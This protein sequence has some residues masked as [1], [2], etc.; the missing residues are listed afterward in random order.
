MDVEGI[1]DAELFPEALRKAIESSDAFVFVI[2]PDAVSSD[3]CVQEVNHAVELNKR[4]VPLTLKPVAAD[5][6]PEAIRFRNWIPVDDG[7][8]DEGVARLVTAIDTDLEWE[9][10]HTRLTVKALEWDQSGRDR[11]AL[12]RGSELVAAE[13]WLAA[14]ADKDP[15]PS[16]I[17][18]EYLLAA[19]AAK[20]RRQ[21]LL[22]G[23]SLGT[24]AVAIGLLI[25][26]LISR[27]EAVHAQRVAVA[28]QL[29]AEA[30]S[31]PRIDRAMLLAREAVKLNRDPQ[32][33]GT[34][35]ATLLRSP[36]AIGTFTLPIDARPQNI[37][38]RPDGR[39]LAVVDNTGRIRF[40][41]P[42]THAPLGKPLT[43][44]AETGAPTYSPDGSL[45]AY[46]SGGRNFPYVA[47]R[48]AHSLRLL[49]RL[50]F[51]H[52][53]LTTPTADLLNASGA[54]AFSPGDSAL[55]YFYWV[56]GPTG[57]PGP[58][59]L[60]RWSLRTGGLLSNTPLGPG[61][62]LA[63]RLVA[64]GQRLVIVNASET[65]VY[66]ARTLRR[67]RTQR[68]TPAPG[69]NDSVGISPDG[70]TAIL[71][72][73]AGSVSFADLVT[74]RTRQGVGG[75]G[76][77]VDQADYSPDGR[78]AVTTSEDEKAIVW[79]PRTAL[80]VEILSGH[81][82]PVHGV[83]FSG[84]GKTLYTS[85]LDGVV[86]GWDLGGKRRFGQPFKV[87]PG[88]SSRVFGNPILPGTPPLAL[89]GDGSRFA[90]RV[91]EST[92][93]VFSTRT[94][95]P[96]GSFTIPKS[97][98]VITVLQW[99]PRS[100]E[101][102]VGTLSGAL[103]LWSSKGRLERALT[104]LPLPRVAVHVVETV[105]FS[106]DG[107]LIAAT[108]KEE[109]PTS[110]GPPTGRLAVWRTATGSLVSPPRELPQPGD[111]LA[112]GPHANE[113]AVGLDTGHVVILDP[114]SG[115]IRRKIT[116]FSSAD[117]FSIVALAFAPDGTLATGS[118]SGIVQ[119]WNP[120]TGQQLGHPVLVSASPV[121]SISFDPS[122]RRFAVAG[123]S[124]GS[125]KIWFTST[126]QQE[127]A[128][129]QGD[130]GAW[131]NA[132]FTPD[133]R[134]LLVLYSDGTGFSWPATVGA[135]G[136][137]ACAVAGRNF[138]REEWSRFVSGYSYTRVCPR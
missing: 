67:L 56:L 106:A 9:H 36:A 20:S 114:R 85:S 47:V 34:L 28:R 58:A 40:Y 102:A 69:P 113:L 12:L 71:G 129:L 14:G 124:D 118:W 83:A 46:S 25:F 111:S 121:G 116:T 88:L 123:G 19:R 21:R 130:P 60:D 109:S 95:R 76:G 57:K 10:Q 66:N 120:A 22:V 7:R 133:G 17:E 32:T 31:E 98:G 15:G 126:L 96:Q 51:D 105:A 5:A 33:E 8:F 82:G 75:H 108:D 52:R 50:R 61:P 45:L 101:L 55:Y 26:A 89:S 43:D 81:A 23:A 1:R 134:R 27:S 41:N 68:I 138:T 90:V 77:A 84:D 103:A 94:L 131:G 80:P 29:G 13:Q 2:S 48:D 65:S 92:V 128:N 122:G 79:D 18:Q 39:A 132:A 24:A 38:L 99:S 91:G 70:R 73:Q 37:S 119:L 30:V 4:I 62:V 64:A 93:R 115:R 72:T 127:G 110:P 6:L 136:Q 16:A 3:F 42:Q 112:F 35:L 87:G 137:H 44:S 104:G 117:G 59:Y 49:H 135:W 54:F 100:S 74:G 53:W 107:S 11:S 63:A 97:E 78:F 125:A 86:L